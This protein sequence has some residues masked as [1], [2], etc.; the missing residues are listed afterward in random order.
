VTD[1]V[2]K[3]WARASAAGAATI[4]RAGPVKLPPSTG[5]M[6]AVKFRDPDGHPLELVQFPMGAATSWAGSGLLGID[7]SA[8]SVADVAVSRRFYRAHGLKEGRPSLNQGPTQ[9]ALDGLDGVEVD[10]VPL[11][12][13]ESPPH[14]ELLGYRSPRGR[15]LGVVS[16]NDIAATRMLWKAERRA[17]VRDPDG[18]LHQ[19]EP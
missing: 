2:D 12:P 11:D 1:N 18:H 10:V 14:L 8:V 16:P 9:E 15:S 17:L 5:G 6:T 13:A 4:S 7:H 3:S 19:L